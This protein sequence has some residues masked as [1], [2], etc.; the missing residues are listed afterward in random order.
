MEPEEVAEMEDEL[1][2]L[3]GQVERLSAQVADGRARA[4]HLQATI[5]RLREEL[6]RVSP[7]AEV[8]AGSFRGRGMD[9]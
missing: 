2:S 3:R 8:T 5:S 4:I 7:P 1:Q 6:R 9:G